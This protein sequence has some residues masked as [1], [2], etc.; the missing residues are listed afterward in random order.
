MFVLA[1][2]GVL[3]SGSENLIDLFLDTENE[4]RKK[5]RQQCPFEKNLIVHFDFRSCETTFVQWKGV[6]A[7][8]HEVVDTKLVFILH[9]YLVIVRLVP[10]P[11]TNSSAFEQ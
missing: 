8:T 11:R 4:K 9:F 1:F 3:G 10:Y 2:A 6:S 7:T 5:D